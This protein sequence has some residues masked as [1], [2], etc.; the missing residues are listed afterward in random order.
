MIAC[1]S[2]KYI[3]KED[4]NGFFLYKCTLH[5]IYKNQKDACNKWEENVDSSQEKLTDIHN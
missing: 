4:I 1:E 5:K 3:S 2:C